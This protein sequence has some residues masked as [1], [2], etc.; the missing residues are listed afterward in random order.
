MNW[1]DRG[2]GFFSPSW[3]YKRSAWRGALRGF[4][5]SGGTDRLNS[6]WTT[7]NATAEQTDQG[8][9]DIIR[10]RARDL[11]RNSD[12]AEG[13][14]GPLE[15]NVVGTGIIVQAKVKKSDGTEDDDLNQQIEDLFTEWSRARNCDVAGI[16]SF[17]EMQAMAIRRIKVDGGIIFV[18]CY[19][20]TGPVPFSLQ[21]REVDELDTSIYRLSNIGQNRIVGGIELD[22]YN[23][24]V[25]YY[26]KQYTPNGFWTGKSERLEAQRVIYLWQKLRPTQIREMSSLAKT[27]PRVRDVNEYVEA[28]SVKERIL[29][30]LSV[31]IKKSTPTGVGRNVKIDS[32]SGYPVKTLSPGM[33][34]ELQPGDEINVV[35]PSGQ[36]SNAKEFISIQQRLAGI[37]QGLSYE[38]VSRDMSQVNYSSARQGLL[39]DQRTYAMWQ[40]FLIEHFC[41]EVYTEFVISAV[42]S[43]KLN[44]SGFW[45]NKSRYLKHEWIAPGWSWI[46]P[47]KEV[48]A[49][50]VALETGQDTLAKICAERGLDWREVLK[51]RAKEIKMSQSLGIDITG[52][53]KK[54]GKTQGGD[55][56]AQDDTGTNQGS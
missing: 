39:E 35:N 34:Q 31:F 25:A 21:A 20:N 33:I 40:K 26:L 30:C 15:R 55:T 18:K 53:E 45:N 5:D 42:L 7:V 47:M 51:Q 24:P 29:A 14:L 9:R 10:A 19:T 28:V 37:G 52:G 27:L 16:Q 36:S 50:K 1:L 6:R 56:A 23:R 11:E 4:Y 54:N 12:I 46:D 38:A 22:Q 2:I 17:L 3:A 44:I 8:Q 48:S 49:N 41:Y 13:I 43:G 32:Q